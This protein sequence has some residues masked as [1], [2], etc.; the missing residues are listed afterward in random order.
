MDKIVI[1]GGR[2][3]EGA[4]KV[5]G[6]KNAALPILVSSLLVARIPITSHD[7]LIWHPSVPR[8]KKAWMI[9]GPSG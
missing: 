4:V 9:L 2:A 7:S 6:S 3:I 8:G 5:S 1:E